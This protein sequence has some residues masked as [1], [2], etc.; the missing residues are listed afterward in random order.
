[1]NTAEL[2][3]LLEHYKAGTITVHEVD[4]GIRNALLEDILTCVERGEPFEM[5]YSAIHN[6]P[7]THRIVKVE[8]DYTPSHTKITPLP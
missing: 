8:I 5:A 6:R 3:K 7:P 1:M 2:R 4:I